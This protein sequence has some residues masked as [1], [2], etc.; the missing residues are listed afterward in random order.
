MILSYEFFEMFI[1]FIFVRSGNPLLI[2]LQSYHVRV[3][4]KIQLDFRFKTYL[5]VLVNVS[6]RFLKFLD[7]LCFW[8]QEIHC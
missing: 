8:G 6:Y 1:L 3:A 2:F 7:Y 5:K 4:S